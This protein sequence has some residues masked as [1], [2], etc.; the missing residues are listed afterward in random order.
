VALFL[1]LDNTILPSKEAYAESISKLASVWKQKELGDE[2]DFL[3]RY[4]EARKIVKQRLE[5]HTS[6]RLRLLCFKEM[7]SEKWNGISVKKTENILDLE[8]SYF[9]FF[10][11]YLKKEKKQNPIWAEVFSSLKS[12]SS[13]RQIFFLTNENLKTQ[14]LKIRAFFPSDLRFHLITSEDIGVEKPDKKY[15]DFALKSSE[16]KP[17]ECY[18]VGDSLGDDIE[19]AKKAGIPAIYQKQRFGDNEEIRTLSETPIVL[20]SENLIST[21]TYISKQ[22]N[23]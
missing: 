14:L 16:S 15:F 3:Y 17:S 2:N 5:G 12:I 1:D 11:D 4:A 7:V 20:E 9:E 8:A 21:F 6:S 10:T 18:M 13:N 23:I 19:G 22:W